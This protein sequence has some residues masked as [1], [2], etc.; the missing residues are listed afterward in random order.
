MG[1]EKRLVTVQKAAAAL[2]LFVL[3]AWVSWVTYYNRMLMERDL[4][5]TETFPMH[6]FV[7]LG[8]NYCYGGYYDGVSI[9]ADDYEI[10]D[11]GEYLGEKNLSR[12]EIRY[13]PEKL[14]IVGI[15][16]SYR[17]TEEQKR[18]SQDPEGPCQE[19]DMG[20]FFTFGDDYYDGQNPELYLVENSMSGGTSGIRFHDGDICRVRL[21]FNLQRRYYTRRSWEHLEE[22]PRELFL[23]GKPV[24]KSIVLCG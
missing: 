18:E 9:R 13:L 21:V 5:P 16:V 7:E 11:V 10:V 4:V 3:A 6:E 1:N 14:C 24:Q 23:T 15:T 22:L 2:L 8:D 19:M 12:D 17:A 20:K